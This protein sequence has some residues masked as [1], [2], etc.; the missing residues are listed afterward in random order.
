MALLVRHGKTRWTIELSA[1]VEGT[2]LATLQARLDEL[3]GIAPAHQKLVHKGR[4]LTAA[5]EDEIKALLRRH[6]PLKVM[7][8]GSSSAA[9]TACRAAAAAAAV[10]AHA[11]R[12]AL[13]YVR[14]EQVVDASG[15]FF[16]ALEPLVEF[17]DKHVASAMLARLAHDRGV[18]AVM[19]RHGWRIGTIFELYPKGKVGMSPSCLMGINVNRGERIGLRL[20]TDDLAGWR[21]YENVRK[22]LF[23]ELTHQE[24]SEH[25]VP[26]NE[27]MSALLREADAHDWTV[28][29]GRRLDGGTVEKGRHGI[30][31]ERQRAV[32]VSDTGERIF[33]G[34]RGTTGGAS[35]ASGAAA[36]REARLRAIRA[37]AVAAAAVAAVE[38]GAA[39]AAVDSAEAIEAAPEPV[40]LEPAVLDGAPRESAAVEPAARAADAATSAVTEPS[41]VPAAVSTLPPPLVAPPLLE[42]ETARSDPTAAQQVCLRRALALLDARVRSAGGGDAAMRAAAQ[43]ALRTAHAVVSNALTKPTEKKYATLRP[44]NRTFHAR[45]GRYGGAELLKAAGFREI[46]ASESGSAGGVALVLRRDQAKLWLARE[47]IA[48][49]LARWENAGAVEEHS[50]THYCS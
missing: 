23:H 16:G 13:R 1:V 12:R 42:R 10:A 48:T 4:D 43:R 6:S 20:R 34:G 5:S 38:P 35:G 25:G 46:S 18:L 26:F 29:A 17:R 37:R 11:P 41:E 7:L 8:I 2:L 24:H 50:Q 22:V 21:P 44:G 30:A 32:V 36:T 45:F 15:T 27:F 39:D 9:V 14:D 40:A 47:E 49:A 3:S 31:S 33:V 19:Q 28:S